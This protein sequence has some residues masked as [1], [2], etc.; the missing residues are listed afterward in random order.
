MLYLATGWLGKP[1]GPGVLKRVLDVEV[2]GV[3]EDCDVLA[4]GGGRRSVFIVG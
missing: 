3:M 4:V 2:L 1:Q